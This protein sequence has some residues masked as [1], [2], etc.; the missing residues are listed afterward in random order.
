[1]LPRD[2]LGRRQTAISDTVIQKLLALIHMSRRR[3][4]CTSRH[5]SQRSSHQAQC[6]RGRAAADQA[7]DLRF[8]VSGKEEACL[9]AECMLIVSIKVGEGAEASKRKNMHSCSLSPELL[10][11]VVCGL[12]DAMESELRAKLEGCEPTGPEYA[13]L[14]SE[15]A[16]L[17]LREV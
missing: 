1:M 3:S 5:C 9:N 6:A 8:K 14:L 17:K 16:E 7:A 12:W 13:A 11:T 4:L 2:A 15:L 10:K